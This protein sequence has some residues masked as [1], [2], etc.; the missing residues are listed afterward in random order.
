MK[1]T[2]IIFASFCVLLNAQEYN[3]AEDEFGEEYI[4]VPLPLRRQ[5]RQSTYDLSHAGGLTTLKLGHT[6][7][8]LDD[9]I[10]KFSL[11]GNLAHTFTPRSPLTL[12]GSLN[13]LHRSGSGISVGVKNTPGYGTDLGVQGKYNILKKGG[14]TFDAV[15]SYSRHYGGS[16]GT[17]TPDWFAGVQLKIPF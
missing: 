10:N 14:A 2:V 13:Y 7:K 8:F 5:K 3:L 11:N 17:L 9:G 12:G 4:M 6:Q 16:S 1:I 15:G